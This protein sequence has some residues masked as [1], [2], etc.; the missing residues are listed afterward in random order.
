MTTAK[1]PST[2]TS[3]QHSVGQKEHQKKKR[4]RSKKK[5]GKGRVGGVGDGGDVGAITAQGG[6]SPATAAGVAPR[7]QKP[8]QRDPP[9]AQQR[10]RPRQQ[11]QPQQRNRGQRHRNDKEQPRTPAQRPTQV[12]STAP[13]QPV[14]PGATAAVDKR[15]PT[16]ASGTYESKG[17]GDQYDH[18]PQHASD[19]GDYSR[20]GRV[21]P[22]SIQ[23]EAGCKT[24]HENKCAESGDP[25]NG[26]IR[27]DKDIV[28]S[29]R[30]T[31]INDIAPF[32]C[33]WT[34]TMKSDSKVDDRKSPKQEICHAGTYNK[35]SH[36]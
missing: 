21:S 17:A 31:L 16:S 4:N 9:L 13:P 10:Q 23:A 11:P 12:T 29:K 26:S 15:I 8:K 7:H 2:E 18:V 35:G 25:G 24:L 14:V 30:T 3:Q 32:G 20:E 36:R 33:S 34:S 5:R 27:H 28:T 19:L 6:S 22:S 1:A